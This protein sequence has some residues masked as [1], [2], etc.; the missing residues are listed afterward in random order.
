MKPFLLLDQ[1]PAAR[2]QNQIVLPCRLA[3]QIRSPGGRAAAR[4]PHQPLGRP[5]DAAIGIATTCSQLRKR[6]FS[7]KRFYQNPVW[8]KAYAR[9]EL[10]TS[11]RST[12]SGIGQNYCCNQLL[13]CICGHF[14]A[15]ATLAFNP[16]GPCICFLRQPCPIFSIYAHGPLHRVILSFSPCFGASGQMPCY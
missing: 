11:A 14:C 6:P 2:F 1:S 15:S 9:R 7:A 3:T 4:C 12:A 5:T 13:H 10:E 16:E 8:S